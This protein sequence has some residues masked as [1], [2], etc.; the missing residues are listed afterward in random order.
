M[1]L[2]L[3]LLLVFVLILVSGVFAATELALVSLRES[4]LDQMSEKSKRGAKVAKVA[5]DPNRFL[6]AAQIGVTFVG[7]FSASYGAT[8]LAPYVEP[9]LTY[10][11]LSGTAVKTVSIIVLTI[12]ISY[13]SL[14][15]GELVP[16]RLAMQKAES[17]AMAVAPPLDKFA[18]VVRPIIWLL[19]KSTNGVFKLIGGDPNASSEEIS[20]EELQSIVKSHDG[21]EDSERQIL[22]DVI[23][24]AN[25]SITEVMRPRGS[26]E[27]LDGD[28]LL[29]DASDYTQD[30]PYSRFPVIGKD[31]DDV[32]GF[33]HVRDL[34]D[35]GDGSTAGAKKTVRDVT[36]NIL[37][38]PGTNHLF[39]SLMQ[40]RDKGIHIAVVLD[41]Y[42]GTDGICTLEDI[43]EEMIGDIHDEY[44][45][46]ERPESIASKDGSFSVD[47]GMSLEDFH[48][49]TSIEL[50]DGPYETVAGYILANLGEVAKVGDS[51]I[52][53]LMNSQDDEQ[54]TATLL[55]SKVDGMRISRV[56]VRKNSDES[57]EVQ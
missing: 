21:F 30:L 39:P 51:V 3:D 50:A 47:G 23:D 55:V 19:S 24:A 28:L 20:E 18:I 36:R 9:L 40:M 5:R 56:K 32:L 53:P 52:V 14:V 54:N 22:S 25:R 7:F 43:I 44:D 16:K 12:L 37:K 11:G 57:S 1:K 34:F 8:T 48:D 38:F 35:S 41:E 4:Q 29:A 2:A 17:I 33:V 6:S 27:F 31:F 42:G 26:V 10:I 46:R 45:I 15:F 49:A 13:I